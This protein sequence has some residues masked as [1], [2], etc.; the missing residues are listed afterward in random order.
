MNNADVIIIGGGLCGSAIAYCCSRL[1]IRVLLLERLTIGGNGATMHSRGIVRVYDPNPELMRWAAEAVRLW[2]SWDIDTAKPF[3]ECGVLYLLAPGNC[4]SA[5]RAVST[6]SDPSYPIIVLDGPTLS[7][8]FPHLDL[9]ADGTSARVALFEPLGGYCDPRLAARLYAHNA[10]S[11]G[12][13]VLEGA[14]VTAILSSDAGIKVQVDSSWVES[15]LAVIAAGAYSSQLFDSLPLVSRTIPIT[16]FHDPGGRF[17][18]CVIIDEATGVYVR[19]D[20]PFHYYCGGAAQVQSSRPSE[21]P[22]A[23]ACSANQHLAKLG[24]LLG[25]CPG[26]PLYSFVGF[27]G[28]TN[29]YLPLIGFQDP[30]SRICVAT[31]FSGR[32]AK[33]IPAVAE[34]VSGM[35]GARLA[36]VS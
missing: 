20:P 35:I 34:R 19:P 36:H 5:L 22:L 6:H 1:G 17:N 2:R 26:S 31:G 11:L 4:E 27:D 33:Y 12:G 15:K 8:V 7:N 14:D 13:T 16:C 10:R 3:R 25:S 28:Y 9:K 30:H 23:D 29:D 21:L 32:G 24:Q 18:D